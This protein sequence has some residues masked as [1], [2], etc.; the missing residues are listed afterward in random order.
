MTGGGSIVFMEVSIRSIVP[1]IDGVSTHPAGAVPSRATRR[2]SVG[3]AAE[4]RAGDRSRRRRAG[5]M[6]GKASRRAFRPMSTQNDPTATGFAAF[7]IGLGDR[8]PDRDRR[9]QGAGDPR[10]PGQP[11][12]RGRRDPR[13]RLA[14]PRGRALGGEHRRSRG[15]RAA[16]RR[17]DEVPRQGRHQGR[18]QRQRGARQGGRRPRR[19]R[20]DRPRHGDDRA[21]GTPNKGKLGAN[22]ILGVSL[23]AA[24][25]AAD[26]RGPAALSLPRRRQAP[27]SCRCR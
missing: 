19:H 13:R 18:R 24:K 15:R 20:P 27:A 2:K 1:A 23:A 11:D 17:Q 10:Q 6:S 8:G 12:R 22:A 25:A 9:R 21:D 14:R 26:Q 7:E 3:L 16:R 4:A 5:H